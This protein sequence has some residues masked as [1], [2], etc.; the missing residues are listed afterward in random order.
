MNSWKQPLLAAVVVLLCA[1]PARSQDWARK[2]FDKTTHDFGVVAR[3]GSAECR[4]V[5]ENI[6][7]ED[8]HIKAVVSHCRCSKPRYAKTL[9]KTWEKTEI[10]VGLDTRTESGRKDGTIEVE[11]DQPYEAKV[12][13]HV[14][15]FIREDV[16][17]RPGAVQF[18]SV[19]QG[20]ETNRELK[21]SYAPGQ[22]DWRIRRVECAN[23]GIEARVEEVGR[24]GT[25]IDYKLLVKLRANAAAGYIQEPLILV[26][27]DTD[28][29]KARIPVNVDGQVLSALTARPMVLMMG[30][31]EIGRPVTSNVVVQGRGPFRV[32]AIRCKD[33]RFSG[34]VP[35]AAKSFHVIPI[36][37]LTDD[38]KTQPGK[39]NARIRI[40]TDLGGGSAVDVNASVE[41]VAGGE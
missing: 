24:S 9:L 28:P 18:G 20:T 12:Q 34:K 8:A 19:S 2:M 29:S 14:H 17:V 31:A 40:E 6:Y 32:L 3:G 38:A 1:G 10:V 30:V 39:V 4:F 16:V 25:Q 36:T 5:I 13:L 7:E 11:F 23:P 21:V 33:G 37:F 15:S 35:S 41:V 27:N 26:T 22:M